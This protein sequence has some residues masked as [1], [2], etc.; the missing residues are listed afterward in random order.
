MKVEDLSE[1]AI[2]EYARRPNDVLKKTLQMA[3]Y[4]P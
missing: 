4:V 2:T 1:D 3:M